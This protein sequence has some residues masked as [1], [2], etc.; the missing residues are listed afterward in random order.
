MSAGFRAAARADNGV[1]P[2]TDLSLLTLAAAAVAVPVA[3]CPFI[4]DGLRLG[5]GLL[6]DAVLLAGVRLPVVLVVAP[7]DGGFFGVAD[8]ALCVCA[9]RA[10]Q[11]AGW[12]VLVL[13]R[14][15]LQLSADG[16]AS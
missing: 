9:V 1:P 8:M 13:S 6:L 15:T 5:A 12:T 7:A 11:V 3:L 4:L 2:R 16:R 10:H 14:G